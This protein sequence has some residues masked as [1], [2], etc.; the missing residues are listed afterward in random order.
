[1]SNPRSNNFQSTVILNK[2]PFSI[3]GHFQLKIIFFQEPLVSVLPFQRSLH[4][5]QLREYRQDQDQD[6]K[7]F[8]GPHSTETNLQKSKKRQEQ[9]VNV[10]QF[11]VEKN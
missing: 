11:D 3:N 1:M 2:R 9:K 10:G 7:K 8:E 6:N 4:R 5:L